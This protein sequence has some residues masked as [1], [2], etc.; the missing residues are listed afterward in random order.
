MYMYCYM[1]TGVCVSVTHTCNEAVVA[2]HHPIRSVHGETPLML[3]LA[4]DKG[5]GKFLG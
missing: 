5:T 3:G 1:Q 2:G 4:L